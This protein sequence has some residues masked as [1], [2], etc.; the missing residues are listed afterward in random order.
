MDGKSGHF[1]EFLWIKKKIAI[2]FM[3]RPM[4]LSILLSTAKAIFTTHIVH[5]GLDLV[6][7]PAD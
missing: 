6:S 2:F 7:H 4:A 3:Q 1:N 5:T